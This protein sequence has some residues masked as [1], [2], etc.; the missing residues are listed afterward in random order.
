MGCDWEKVTHLTVMLGGVPRSA[1]SDSSWRIVPFSDITMQHPA[2]FVLQ[3]QRILRLLSNY[4]KLRLHSSRLSCRRFKPKSALEAIHEACESNL[5]LC[6]TGGN[7]KLREKVNLSGLNRPWES[8]E[9]GP[10]THGTAFGCVGVKYSWQAAEI[11]ERSRRMGVWRRGEGWSSCS[12][13]REWHQQGWRETK[14]KDR[15]DTMKPSMK[16]G[17]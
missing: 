16:D 10:L 8:N 1:G 12:R 5:F 9:P 2:V 3:I 17:R 6:V 13:E 7:S 15:D 11:L 14:V 4:C